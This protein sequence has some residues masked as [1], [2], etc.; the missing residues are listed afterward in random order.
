MFPKTMARSEHARGSRVKRSW[1]ISGSVMPPSYQGGQVAAC[2]S[3]SF[4]WNDGKSQIALRRNRV[5][6]WV[7]TNDSLKVANTWKI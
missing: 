1:V 7:Y 3:A 2:V 4:T 5:V 6:T